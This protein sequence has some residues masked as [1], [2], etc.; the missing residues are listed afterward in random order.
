MPMRQ[1]LSL[2]LSST[3][4]SMLIAAAMGHAAAQTSPSHLPPF[5]NCS[6]QTTIA[7]DSDVRIA[8][9]GDLVFA[10]NA[11]INR[12]TFKDFLPQLAQADLALGNLEGAI[13]THPTPRKAYV[14]GRSY[15]FRFPVETADLLKKANFHILSIA[16]NHS[17]DYGPIGFADTQQ[18]LSAAGLEYTGLK[19]SHVIR[20]IKGVRVGV[21]ALAHY[22]VYNNVL[23]I[24]GTARLVAQ[25]RSKSDIVVL[26][27]QLGGEGDSHALLT[28]D[29]AVFLG[30]Q[31]GNA[32]K[33][34]AAMV[35]AGASALIGH[36]PHLV[37]AAECMAGVP[38]LHSI[39]NFVG[40]GG[41]STRS[42]ANVTVF[43]ELIFE[44]SGRF[45]GVRLT[46]TTFD[47]ERLPIIDDSGRALHLVNWF[48]R[49]AGK[50]L[51]GFEAL[52]FP[53]YEQ[54]TETFRK[55]FRSTPFGLQAPRD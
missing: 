49:Q 19:D 39:G 34:A 1:I 42:L 32:R 18:H 23:D 13:T 35:K 55:W 7:E 38:V 28:D 10:D 52:N 51:S 5:V 17:N 37:R 8:A 47:K 4:V 54:Q 43:A 40:A 27:Y 21:I 3:V 20:T 30:E 11:Q 15:A 12:P 25:V 22:P 33:F 9:V 36:G 31:R 14:P 53:G 26:F 45:K 44:A 29:D 24:E 2:P 41:L 48:N 50:S 16:N 46:P 6:A